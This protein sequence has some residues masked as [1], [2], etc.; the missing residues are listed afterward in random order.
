MFENLIEDVVSDILSYCDALTLG[1]L[2]LTS[3]EAPSRAWGLAPI[4]RLPGRANY[5]SAILRT[6]P[7]TRCIDI[8]ESC[9]SSE[10]VCHMSTHCIHLQQLGVHFSALWLAPGE[11]PRLLSK[12]QK[13]VVSGM[14]KDDHLVRLSE[15]VRATPR[16]CLEHLAVDCSLRSEASLES[17]RLMIEHLAPSLITV[18]AAIPL[19]ASVLKSTFSCCKRLEKLT[20]TFAIDY[21][22]P[23]FTMEEVIDC[24]RALEGTKVGLNLHRYDMP[25]ETVLSHCISWEGVSFSEMISA[26]QQA[27]INHVFPP[28]VL[29]SIL[30]ATHGSA[31]VLELIESGTCPSLPPLPA[32]AAQVQQSPFWRTRLASSFETATFARLVRMFGPPPPRHLGII[33]DA[34]TM[35]WFIGAVGGEQVRQFIKHQPFLER[36]KNINKVCQRSLIEIV[37][38]ELQSR[39]L[40]VMRGDELVRAVQEH[41]LDLDGEVNVLSLIV[42]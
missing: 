6:G 39:C 41:L 18:E 36:I 33:T 26:L 21:F 29:P 3:K 20:F 42:D 31:T 11:W 14:Y 5:E 24:V 30:E 12:I 15:I 8:S 16:T 22:A 9:V 25:N 27:R 10:I 13:I 40:L 32:I 37:C 34:N 35:R 19:D 17:F 7:R 23:S 28:A 2:S 1:K 4:L 38:H